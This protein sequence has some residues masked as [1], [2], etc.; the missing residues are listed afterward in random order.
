MLFLATGDVNVA[1]GPNNIGSNTLGGGNFGVGD[2][3]LDLLEGTGS[4]TNDAVVLEF[5]FI[6]IGDT[7]KFNYVFGS[8]EYPEFVNGGFND[9]FGFFLSGP[10]IAGPYSNNAT[11]IALV[12]GTTTPVTIDNVNSGSNPSY[13]VDNTINTGAQ[14]IQFDGYTTVMT[15]IGVVQ[16][17]VQ[18]HIKIAIAD[19]GD[20]SYDS[21]VF[22]E[23]GSFSSNTV[24][25]S[26]NI[27]INGNDSILY[28]GCGTA[29][30]DFVRDNTTDTSIYN[31]TITGT[32]GTADYSIS[33]N[34]VVFL[35]GQDTI[36]LSFNALQDGLTEP[37]E[38]VVIQLIQVVCNMPDTQTVTFYISDYPEIMLNA[39]EIL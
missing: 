1:V 34:S 7:V 2:P 26:S 17:G 8:E 33:N 35:P 24:T 13:Y 10:G 16:C 28:E 12:P 30:L 27:D 3:D 20:A 6:P 29:F 9:A 11:N 5:D 18:Y 38:T 19:V 22:I 23:G 36:T 4:G 14:S 15:A 21:G 31:F 32:A 37:L 25:L 39:N